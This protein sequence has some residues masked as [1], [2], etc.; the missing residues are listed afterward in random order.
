M[1]SERM[2]TKTGTFSYL[3]G[4]IIKP[5]HDDNLVDCDN[6]NSACS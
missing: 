1:T 5:Q 2:Q 3:W 4:G 6:K